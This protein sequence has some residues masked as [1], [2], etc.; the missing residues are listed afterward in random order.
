MSIEIQYQEAKVKA[1]QIFSKNLLVHCPYFNQEVT[2]NSDGFHHLQFSDRRE[3]SK[4]EQL[5]KFNLLP[6]ALK[7]IRKSGTIQEYRKS[8]SPVG[9]KST[10]DGLT[11]MKAVQYW[12]L[13]AIV[14]DEDKSLKI[15]VILRQVG[16]GKITFWSVM[17]AMKLSRDT[18][19]MRYRLATKGI[20]DD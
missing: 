1:S 8:L 5:L 15:K 17:P 2:L 6:L 19:D 3:R 13:I 4:N 7:I 20:E 9:K 14:G 18:V 10:R 11:I 12:A 16:D